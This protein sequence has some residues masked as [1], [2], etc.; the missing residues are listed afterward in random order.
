[1]PKHYRFLALTLASSCL[2]CG[3]GYAASAPAGDDAAQFSAAGPASGL[4]VQGKFVSGGPWLHG[5]RLPDG[6]VFLPKPA[7]F[8]LG[9]RSKLIAAG[10]HANDLVLQGVI[11]PDPGHSAVVTSIEKGLLEKGPAGFPITGTK[12][13]RGQIL[14]SIR[15]VLE[16]ADRIKRTAALALAEQ[17]LSVNVQNMRLLGLQLVGQNAMMT[18]TSFQQNLITERKAID[19]RIVEIKHV[20]DGHTMLRAPIDGVISQANAQIGSL[21]APGQTLFEIIDPDRLWVEVQSYDVLPAQV[22]GQATAYTR[23]GRKL[24]LKFEGQGLTATAQ[25]LPLDFSISPMADRIYV[26]QPVSV[27]MRAKHETTGMVLPKACVDRAPDGDDQVWLQTSSEHFVP[28]DVEV[29]PR[30]ASTVVIESGI[31]PGDRVVCQGAWILD[32]IR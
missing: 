2:L 25:S 12:V 11:V 32:Q 26:G 31:K 16:S 14:G 7:Q 29:G 18:T 3:I 15:P 4:A 24:D 13:K 19:A 21:V 10:S 9:I 28:H 30:A 5:T 22:F 6:S 1:M 8:S 27:T 23:D 20:L 17:D